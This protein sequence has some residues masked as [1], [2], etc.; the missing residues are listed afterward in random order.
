MKALLSL[1]G[2]TSMTQNRPLQMAA[3]LSALAAARRSLNVDL[4]AMP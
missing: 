1:R 3:R 2:H 4:S